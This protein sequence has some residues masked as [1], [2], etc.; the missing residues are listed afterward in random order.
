MKQFIETIVVLLVLVI[1]FSSAEAVINITEAVIQDGVVHVQGNQAPSS[2]A[3]FWE[4]VALGVSSNPGGAFKFDTTDLPEDCVGRL[5]IGTEKRD[6]VINDCTPASAAAAPVPQTGQT[7]SFDTNKPQRDDG[8]L[9]KGVPLPNPRFIDNSN[10]TITDKLTGLIWLKNANC[11]N[12]TR[13]WQGAL[14][15]VVGIN[16]GTNNCGDTSNEGSHQTDWRLP[17]IRELFSLV[18]FAFVNPA[19]SNA[20]GTGQGSG[21]DPF[22]NFQASNYWSSTTFAGDSGFAWGV[23]FFFGN[24]FNVFKGGNLLV[25]AV[26]G[27]S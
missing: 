24:V 17:N 4:G 11:P 10:G 27:G 9:Q 18:D 22:S 7:T 13:V 20:A 2:A 15:F 12:G 3:I 25:T 8:A 14:D 26:R 16:N 5:K 6:V 19:I 23:N 1:F 21:S